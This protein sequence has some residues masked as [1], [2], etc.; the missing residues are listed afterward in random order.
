MDGSLLATAGDDKSIQVWT[1]SP[2]G[3]ARHRSL[4]RGHRRDV[5]S[6][7]FRP[8]GKTLLTSS[9]DQTIGFWNLENGQPQRFIQ[10]DDL[11]IWSV[12]ANPAGTLLAVIN[13][14][15]IRLLDSQSGRLYKE[16]QGHAP[17]IWSLALS[18]DGRWL[19]SGGSDG[20]IAL[21]DVHEPVE[22]ELKTTLH[23]HRD[24]VFGVA[25]HPDGTLLAG[26]SADHTVSLWNLQTHQLVHRLQGHTQWVNM[27]VF[28]PDGRTL[29]SGGIDETIRLWDTQSGDSLGVMHTPGPY[30][31]MN[32]SGATGISDTEKAILKSLGAVEK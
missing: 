32:I 2:D 15:N 1:I 4:L 25:F 19:A 11:P 6:L 14:H 18:P 10:A 9:E 28:S 13:D 26:G 12:K 21:W 5:T 17:F 7:E 23:G 3:D 31:G 20:S 29:A 16:L 22:A 24:R 8:G 30:E 27:V